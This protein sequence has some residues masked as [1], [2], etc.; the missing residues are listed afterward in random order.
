VGHAKLQL[1][2]H[3]QLIA[4]MHSELGEPLPQECM[5]RIVVPLSQ[6]GAAQHLLRRREGGGGG[7]HNSPHTFLWQRLAQL[8]VHP[9]NELEETLELGMPQ[10][11]S[12]KAGRTERCR[13]LADG[14]GHLS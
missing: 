1:K 8:H 4:W 9:C 2:R 14:N 11:C 12:S 6:L 3:F 10:T 7:H 13:G 5:G